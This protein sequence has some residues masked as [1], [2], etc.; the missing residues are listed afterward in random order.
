MKLF[1]CFFLSFVFASSTKDAFYEALEAQ[2]KG[3]GS[4]TVEAPKEYGREF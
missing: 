1:F 2:K 3:A 4:L